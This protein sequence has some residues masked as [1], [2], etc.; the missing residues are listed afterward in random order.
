M[1]KRR[2]AIAGTAA[3]LGLAGM[4]GTALADDRVHQGPGYG[5]PGTVHAEPAFV[6]GKLT[7]WVG[8]GKAVK[9]SKAKVA[10]LI[11]E[12]VIEPGDAWDIAA[13]GVTVVPA[14]RLWISVPGKELPRKVVGKRWHERRVVHLTCVWDEFAAK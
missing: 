7:C 9:F 10:E 12:K 5:G 8:G 4:A 2:L 14:D 13:D 11:D 6:G 1:L 3:V